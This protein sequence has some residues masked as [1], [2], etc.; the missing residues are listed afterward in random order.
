MTD[1]ASN[2]PYGQPAGTARIV[3]LTPPIDEAQV[4]A[5]RAG[6]MVSISGVIL[7][8]R[9]AAHKWMVERLIEGRP[10]P[11]D[12]PVYEELKRVLAG[13][14]VFHCGPIV[15][16]VG[17]RWEF[18]SA[19]PTTS[20]RTEL[21]EHRVIEHFGVRMV[22]GKGG[23]GP[24]TLEALQKFK[25]VYVHGIGGAGA[26]TAQAVKEVLA[27]YKAEF[28]LPEALWKIRVEKL[29]GV[30]TMDSYGQSLHRAVEEA[31]RRHLQS[32]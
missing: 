5:L 14:V 4:L 32:S 28:G 3:E 10:E 27:V 24:R 26:L 21:Y 19:G 17:A 18:V 16:R 30:V 13:G 1:V 12:L 11:E 2:V 23:M 29:T 20:A 15:R 22:V 31:S 25:A 9:D 6:D 7:T 8:A